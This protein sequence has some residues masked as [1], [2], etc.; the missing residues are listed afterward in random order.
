MIASTVVWAAWATDSGDSPARIRAWMSRGRRALSILISNWPRRA[1]S[2][3]SAAR[4]RSSTSTVNSTP[5][6]LTRSRRFP[7]PLSP[8]SV[9]WAIAGVVL[10]VECVPGTA[11]DAAEP[12]PAERWPGA[13]VTRRAPVTSG[14]ELGLAG[15]PRPGRDLRVRDLRRA[16]RRPQGPRRLRGAGARRH[17]RARRR[18]PARRPDRRDPAGGAGRLA[19]P[20]GA[21]GRR[22]ASRSGSTRS[23]GRLERPSTSSTPSGWRCSASPARSRRA[24]Y[25]LGPVPGRADGHGDRHRRRDAPRPAR[26]PGAAGVPRRALRDPGPGGSGDRGGRRPARA[27]RSLLSRAGSAPPSAWAGGCSRCGAT[28]RRPDARGSASV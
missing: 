14:R 26:R 6:S 22:A 9:R 10:L 28:G 19:L 11:P 4:R 3:R 23:S 24:E 12:T 18:V 20:A 8:A 27:R 17:D 2:P 21:G 13:I 16:G 15:D 5:L 1:W 7:S 25:G